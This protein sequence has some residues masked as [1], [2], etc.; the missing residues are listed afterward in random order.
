M[1]LEKYTKKVL[2][3]FTFKNIAKQGENDDYVIKYAKLITLILNKVKPR[4][5]KH[6]MCCVCTVPGCPGTIFYLVGL[7]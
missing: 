7:G 5:T 6:K 2:I 3:H 4:L 1:K